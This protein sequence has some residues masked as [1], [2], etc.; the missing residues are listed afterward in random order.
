MAIFKKLSY[1]ASAAALL[2]LAPMAAVHAQTTSA[3]LRGEVVDSAGQPISGATVT[4]I[5]VES[6]TASRAVTNESGA[7]FQGGLR[8]G[9]PF[10]ILISAPGFEGEAIDGVSLRPGSNSPLTIALNDQARD[11]IVVT[12]QAINQTDLNNGVGS[13][14]SAS[15][16]ANQPSATRD[17]IATLVRDPLAFS[18]GEGQ[19]FVAGTNPRFNGL[20]IDGSLQQDDFGLGSNTYATERSPISLDAV[21]SASLVAS[22]YSVTA[23]GF[24]GGLVNITTRSGTNEFDGSAYYYY[25]DE[26]YFGDE[27]DGTAVT[28]APFDEKEYGVTLGGP[29]IKDRLFFFVSYDEFESGS[30]FNFVPDDQNDDIDPS[31][32]SAFSDFVQAELGYDIGDRP[33]VGALPVTSE[34]LLGKI[35][36]NITDQHRA[37]FTYQSTEESGTSV[38]RQDF[39]TAW[40]DI[41]VELTAYT[42]QLFSD[43]SDNFSTTLRVNYKEFTRGQNCRAGSDQPH[44]EFRL[45]PNDLAGSQFDGLIGGSSSSDEFFVGGCDRF[46]HANVFEDERL[47]LF[48]SGD[49]VWGD[50]LITAG[51]EYE[52]YS[53]FNVFVSSSNGRFIFNN[54]DDI[55]NGTARVEYQNA[56]SNNVN[57]GAAAWGLEKFT[58][59]AQDTWQV[60]NDL[61]LGFGFRWEFYSQ[62]D[63]PP[64]DPVVDGLYGADTSGQNLNGKD[65]FMPRFSFRYEPTDRTTVTGG[66][67]VFAGGEPKVWISNS[68]TP[69]LGFASGN[70]FA[71]GDFSVPDALQNSVSGQSGQIIDSIDEDFEI[72]SDLKASLRVDHE[73]NL[74]RFGLGDGYLLSAQ[75]LYTQAQDAFLWRNLAQIDNGAA[76]PTGV[77]PDGRPIYADLDALGIRNLTQLTNDDGSEGHV[78]SISAQKDYDNGFGFYTAYAYQDVEWVSEGGSSRGISNWRGISAIDRNFPEVRTSY[79]EIEHSFK[80]GLSYER[81]FI[82]D[83]TSRVDVFGEITSGAPYFLAYDIGSSNS[84]FGRAGQ[85][86]S[87]Y[88]NNPIYVPTRTGDPNVV[89]ASGFDV[90]GFYEQVARAGAAEGEI[91]PVN[92]ANSAWNQQWDLRFS[93]E[94]PGIPGVS[95]FVGDNNFQLVVDV[96]NFPNLIN[97]DWGV[98]TDGPGFGQAA[99]VVADLV[100]ASDVAANGIDGATALTGDAMRTTCVS[101][102]SCLYRYNEFDQDRIDTVDTFDSL[103]QIRIGLRY[104]F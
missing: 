83:L 39:E 98:Q 65:L 28:V 74:D 38:G 46:R 20:A 79:W 61:E 25:Q 45:S 95:R 34:R 80:I 97:S 52:D 18:A 16:I 67:G 40:Y 22:D 47:Q 32:Y 89:F 59:F 69:A 64:F 57:D 48:A 4:V 30:G 85:G 10:S 73:L 9:G 77:A 72:P 44:L 19:L 100:E 31:F 2:A 41:P 26:N 35:D 101:A 29:I 21:E 3:A 55:R 94:L 68:F 104:E 43:W 5:H 102:G 103:Y 93:Q 88:D 53:L 14:F 66:L 84:L 33:N 36:W 75:Y 12:G 6:G 24:T 54:L 17:V 63:T 23:S 90:D 50:H 11:I 42:G 58:L 96:I 99:V 92:S 81:D 51:L 49:Y 87:P 15:D 37:S 71:V 70:G 76:L 8:V 60:R 7:F 86:E 78:F 62:D 13:N 56:P 82:Q 1:G 91:M 27:T